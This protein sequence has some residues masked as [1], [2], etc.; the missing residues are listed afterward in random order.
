MM[1]K[2]CGLAVVLMMALP[3]AQAAESPATVA[4]ATTIDGAKAKALFDKGVV[5][6]DMRTD[7]D[8]GAGRIPGAVHLEL[9]KVF[10]DASLGAKV[11]K[12]Q[13]VVM[14]CNGVSCMRSSEASAKAVGWG[15]KKVHYYRLGFP[16]WKAA[17]Y[18]VE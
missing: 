6:V 14:Y 3:M 10:S 13:D 2:A 7:K 12:D 16:D 1:K 17:G 8:W 18:P 4:G 5:F 9:S 11:K 15:Y